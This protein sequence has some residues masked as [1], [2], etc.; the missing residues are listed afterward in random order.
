MH[1]GFELLARCRVRKSVLAHAG[2][3]Q[4]ASGIEKIGAKGAGNVCHGCTASTGEFAGNLV[5]IDQR[6]TQLHQ[7]ARHGA[8]AAANAAGQSQAGGVV[9]ACTHRPSAPR[10]VCS[11]VCGPQMRAISPAPTRNGPNGT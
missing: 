2:A 6:S 8:F 10:M 9:N 3:I 11:T 5:G 7:H 1:D 4:G